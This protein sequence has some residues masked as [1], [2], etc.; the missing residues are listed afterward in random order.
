M[1]KGKNK[2][3]N[4]YEILGVKRDATA[5]EI[6]KAY[7][8]KMKDNHPDLHPDDK[9]L[10]EK[11]KEI[12]EAYETLGNEEKRKQYDLGFI[13]NDQSRTAT[14]AGSTTY[15]G[16][17]ASSRQTENFNSKVDEIFKDFDVFYRD[18][19]SAGTGR[20]TDKERQI[21]EYDKLMIFLA[22]MDEKFKEFG[23]DSSKYRKT[24]E[25]KRGILTLKEITD[26]KFAIEKQLKE[27]KEKAKDYDAFIYEYNKHKTYIINH[28]GT[29]NEE[30]FKKYLDKKNR[31]FKENSFYKEAL[32]ELKKIELPLI[33]QHNERVNELLSTLKFRG[34]VS[35]L[36]NYMS[37]HGIINSSDLT[38]TDLNNIVAFINLYD[39]VKANLASKKMSLE[40]I[41]RK[42]KRD[43]NSLT[44][45]ELEIINKNVLEMK[46]ADVFKKWKLSSAI[47]SEI[48]ESYHHKK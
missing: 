14:Y 46:E 31:G 8:R 38:N 12:N 32:D 23:L 34:L 17:S 18:I 43:K 20:T 6:R 33:K 48:N 37:N 9:T 41:L 29:I 19:S 40:D 35:Y 24:L 4:Y 42:L 25:G 30:D 28:G 15:T 11:T 36:F 16:P 10:E 39:Q 5:E 27:L 45:T 7:R 21:E 44:L 47:E 13:T 1:I 22:E 3:P 26:S 2:V